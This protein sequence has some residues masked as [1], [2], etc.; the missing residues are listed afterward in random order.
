MLFI[1]TS[2]SEFCAL[3]WSYTLLGTQREIFISY[4]LKINWG[5][6]KPQN[7]DGKEFS[8]S[9]TNPLGDSQGLC[10]DVYCV[11]ILVSVCV[12][13]FVMIQF[14]NQ[15]RVF[16]TN[17]FLSMFTVYLRKNI[18]FLLSDFIYFSL[19]KNIRKNTI[20]CTFITSLGL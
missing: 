3:R 5:K 13:T 1:V 14:H 11:I 4:T 19:I 8:V 20:W 18:F 6:N 17:V 10:I 12:V 16:F 9:G 2:C 15:S 7:V